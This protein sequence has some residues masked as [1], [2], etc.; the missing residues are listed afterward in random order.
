MKLFFNKII[1][2]IVEDK[3]NECS[4]F[5]LFST[6]KIYDHIIE[7]VNILPHFANQPNLHNLIETSSEEEKDGLVKIVYKNLIDRLTFN[8]IKTIDQCK[9]FIIERFNNEFIEDNE[10]NIYIEF[11]KN[12]VSENKKT[13]ENLIH[14]EL[15]DNKNYNNFEKL[16]YEIKYDIC[17]DIINILY[18]ITHEIISKK[19]KTYVIRKI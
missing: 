14:S 8:N 19:L 1:D 15:K 10:D 7:S 6:D 11:I 17:E 4:L 9:C 5:F 12:Y 18:T 16:G 13:Y 2:K 3:K